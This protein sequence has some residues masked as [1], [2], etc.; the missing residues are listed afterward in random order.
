MEGNQMAVR[1][2]TNLA[3]WQLEP[4]K[5]AF[6]VISSLEKNCEVVTKPQ[7]TASLEEEMEEIAAG[8]KTQEGVVNDSS[9]KLN[10]VIDILSEKKREIGLE[11]KKSVAQGNILAKCNKCPDGDLITRKSKIGKRFVGCSAYPKC[12]NS[13]PLPQKGTITPTDEICIECAAPVIVVR[14]QRFTYKMC[15]NMTCKTKDAWKKPAQKKEEVNKV[16]AK[17]E[18]TSNVNTK[19]TPKSTIKK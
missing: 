5:V 17:K 1:Q 11:I 4:S 10:E 18:T 19:E 6:A 14:N 9:V 13:Y 15:L 2:N 7:M 8:K 3:D 16:E 12:T